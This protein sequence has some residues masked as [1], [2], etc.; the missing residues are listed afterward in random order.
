MPSLF[1]IAAIGVRGQLGLNGRLP[2]HDKTDLEWFR[3]MTCGHE[4]VVGRNTELT[5][6]PLIGR[7][8]L[9]A[10]QFA[11][12]EDLRAYVRSAPQN[13]YLIGGAKTFD[14]FACVVDRWHVNKI[15]YDGPADAWF[16]PMWLVAG[17]E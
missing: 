2:W 3:W 17:L 15:N 6:P 4:V 10:E 14:R 8:I 11:T 13:V 7:T 1:A 9:K 12:P 5:L 16:N